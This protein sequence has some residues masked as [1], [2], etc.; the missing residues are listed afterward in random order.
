MSYRIVGVLLALAAAGCAL[1][2]SPKG[3][4]GRLPPSGAWFARQRMS[5][6]EPIPEGALRRAALPQGTRAVAPGTWTNVGPGNIGGRLTAL[7]VDPND[8]DHVWAGAAAGGV[9]ES[10]DAGNTWTPVFDD[11]PVLNV[12]AVTA[13]PANSGIVYVGTGEANGAGYSYD[14][15]GV[16]RTV[17]GGVSWQHLGLSETRRIGRIAIDPADPQRVFVAAAGGVYTPD[18]FRGVYRSTDGGSTWTQVLF[19]APTAGAIDVAI[20]PVNPARVYAA[21]WE[22]YSTATHW[23][24]GGV[25][26]GIWQSQDGGDSWTRLT[27]GLPAPAASVGRIG[28][29]VAASSP[30]TVYALYLDDPGK[31]IGVY[32]T[33]NAGV[34][35][36]RASSSG[37]KQAF[38]GYGYYCG[39]IRVD[40]TNADAVYVLDGYWA[41]STNGGQGYTMFTGGYVDNHDMVILPDRLYQANDAGFYRSTDAGNT[42]FHPTSLPVTQ[43][44]DLGIDPSIPLR[45]FGGSQDMGSLGGFDGGT[46]NWVGVLNGDGFQC[47]VDPTDSL[48][49]YC[50]SSFGAIHRSVDAGGNFVTAV[51]G[52]AASDRRNWNT[53]IVH[54]PHTALRLYTGTHRVYRSTDGAA[55]W[56]AISGDLTDGVPATSVRLPGRKLDGQ[57]HLENVVEG[58][59][60][61]VAPSGLNLN[62]VW[63]GTDDGHVWVTQNGGGVWTDVDV[64]GRT[65]WVT[66]VEADPFS[67]SSAYVTYSGFR[68]GSPLPRIFRT[69]DFG[70]HWE[71]I[72]GDLPDIPLNGVNADPDPAMRGRLFVASDLGV[73]VTDDYGRSWSAL[74]TG[75]PPVVV[76]DLDLIPSSRQLFA[77]THGRSIYVYD[78]NQLGPADADG[79]GR[80]NLADCRPDDSTVFAAP[81]EVSGLAF[82]SDPMTLSWS[83]AQPSA[84]TATEHQVLRGLVSGL[85]VGGGSESCIAAGTLASSLADPTVPPA[86]AGFWYLVRARNVCGTGTYGS[87]SE[88]APRLG[89]ACP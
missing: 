46:T 47:E 18:G 28:L 76:L 73:F 4:E 61:T 72:G 10:T 33:T 45:R 52:I 44:Y 43:F 41:R 16:Y 26:S 75:I 57:S 31:L 53:P 38:F 2:H 54:D 56:T 42:W 87:T 63:A 89:T 35:W 50:E 27:N 51:H 11:Q 8:F 74:G 21:I 48:R 67:A 86:G 25:N 12:G 14:G 23:V 40:P 83:S 15:D 3:G 22:H 58:T 69:V 62:V 84:G 36:S 13:H 37:A 77:G 34:S 17:D 68:N 88:G 49:V 71:D 5:S 55:N 79:D 64:P 24:A 60:T 7:A 81:G 39:Q 78:L 1:R 9:F 65:E 85:P 6:G 20:D 59:V 19:V 30:S 29:A 70:A 66:R 32:K 82:D 80:E